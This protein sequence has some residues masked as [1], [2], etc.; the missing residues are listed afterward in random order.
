MRKDLTLT[1]I[2][3]SCFLFCVWI[4]FW[5]NEV[6]STDKNLNQFAASVA[7]VSG[8]TATNVDLHLKENDIS[9]NPYRND[10][11]EY[12][13]TKRNLF[14]K[15]EYVSSDYLN[16]TSLKT[17]S[18]FLDLLYV[19]KEWM[20]YLS[21]SKEIKMDNKD[22]AIWRVPLKR[23]KDME[24]PIWEKK[25]RII[26]VDSLVNPYEF[27]VNDSHIIY[28]RNDF[29]DEI[30][31]IY[32][33]ELETKKQEIIY[34]IPIKA[35]IESE[36]FDSCFLMDDEFRNFLYVNG[37]FVVSCTDGYERRLYLLNLEEEEIKYI[38]TQFDDAYD[39]TGI[40][41]SEN[42]F[43]YCTG[44]EVYFYDITK[45]KVF[46]L[47]DKTTVLKK[48]HELNLGKNTKNVKDYWFDSASIHNGK[49]YMHTNICYDKKETITK[50]KKNRKTILREYQRQIVLSIPLDNPK[51]LQVETE[52]FDYFTEN[53]TYDKYYDEGYF[54]EE[55]QYINSIMEGNCY[56]YGFLGDDYIIYNLETKEFT[57]KSSTKSK[58]KE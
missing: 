46:G 43:F 54:A 53:A 25:E 11:Y 14:R 31:Y 35:F 41:A 23:K 42:Q 56:L 2:I 47:V 27:Y 13:S 36:Y 1:I 28:M 48:L 3:A 20:Y 30:G 24:Y 29:E 32:K 18:N 39:I 58:E 26:Y 44:E 22:F 51:N 57:E 49:L 52:L 12:Y 40:G 21:V 8:G 33:L 5:G 6:D 9:F 50:R 38:F 55:N 15:N 17:P 19:T 7:A 37:N 45:E 4:A 16:A 34:R 10:K